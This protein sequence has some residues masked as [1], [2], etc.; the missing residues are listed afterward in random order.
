M[1]NDF[2]GDLSKNRLLDLMAPLLSKKKSGM[3]EIKG[4]QMGEIYLEGSNIIH[5]KTG[6]LSGEEA[7]LAMMEWNAGRATFDWEAAAGEQTVFMPTEQL[8][9]ISKNREAEW[10]RIRE[11]IPSSN[12]LFQMPVSGCPD[13]RSI[14]ANQWKILALCNGTRSVAEVA[15]AL[16]QQLF[17]ASQTLFGMVQDGL[18]ERSGEKKTEQS[19]NV[20]RTVNGNFFPFIENELKK[21]M[22]PIA[23][24][25]IDDKLEEFAESRDSFPEDR[26]PSFV[27]AIGEEIPDASKR[28]QFAKY[29][30]EHI[31]RKK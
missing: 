23:P 7:I 24:I 25:V 1:P 11:L 3:I 17:E 22:G 12:S 14:H 27:Q 5:A 16:N 19:L 18:L 6:E 29:M 20:R 15:E 31:A 21:I 10:A 28:T 2:I 9:M 4:S 13:E 26:L 8:L 30:A